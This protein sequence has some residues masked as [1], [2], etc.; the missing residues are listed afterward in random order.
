[1]TPFDNMLE[2][3]FYCKMNAHGELRALTGGTTSIFT[4]KDCINRHIRNLGDPAQVDF[5]EMDYIID[6]QNH[7]PGPNQGPSVDDILAES[8]TKLEA[9]TL[10]VFLIHLAEGKANDSTTKQEFTVL[11]DKGLL[12]DKTIIIHGISFG[13]TEFQFMKAS[14]ASL[15]WSPRSNIELYGQTMDVITAKNAG[16]KIA[17]APDWAITGS[18]NMLE[19]LQYASAWNK[20]HLDGVLSDKDLVE[21]VTSIPA[22]MI[23]LENKLGS[24]IP[25]AW[26]DLLI[27][28]GDPSNPYGALV[29]AGTENVMLV[30]VNGVAVYGQ[31]L[32]MEKFYSNTML[33]EVLST[34][35]VMV[36]KKP[37]LYGSDKSY[38]EVANLLRLKMAEEKT[39]LAPLFERKVQFP[40]R[41]RGV[42][43]TGKEL[44]I[45]NKN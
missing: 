32:L 35:P 6:I 18:K 37:F 34:R 20:N 21:M 42:H 25:G 26:A 39:S 28:S 11:Q 16:L 22:S 1:M 40:L 15:V 8:K 31:R 45:E 13:E 38:S 19:E 30:I 4:S 23:G 43:V 36:M 5:I 41:K 24:I 27:V 44:D 33:D 3:G 10:D 12:T 2:D 29:K 17:L 9:G 14:G 7:K